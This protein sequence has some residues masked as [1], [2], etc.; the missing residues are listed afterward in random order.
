MIADLSGA[1]I[2]RMAMSFPLADQLDPANIIEFTDDLSG[3]LIPSLII[4]DSND[5]FNPGTYIDSILG[6][7]SDF[8]AMR[9]SNG[10]PTQQSCVQNVITGAVDANV[11][12]Q[13]ANAIQTIRQSAS[14]LNRI[15]TFVT[16]QR[17]SLVDRFTPI[18]GCVERL[19]R[20]SFCG[21][22]NRRIPPLCRGSCNA[23]VR[24]CLSPV[25]SAFERDFRQLWNVTRSIISQ[26]ERTIRNLFTEQ[27]QIITNQLAVVS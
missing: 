5:I 3:S 25:Y 7:L 1:F 24:G 9:L 19:A 6:E 23:L 2:N 13:L 26:L 8:A 17:Q 27:G 15:Q 22:C 4:P 14:A 21:R 11:K 18:R 16:S 20:Q 10:D 12:M